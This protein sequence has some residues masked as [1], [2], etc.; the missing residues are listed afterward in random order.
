MK[1]AI[2]STKPFEK[3]FLEAANSQG[4]ELTFFAE[5]LS[6]ST[7]EKTKGFKAVSI[8]TNDDGS[9]KV[10]SRLAENKVEYIASRCA[11]IDNI[12]LA[13][14][15]SHGIKVANVPGYSPY[16]IAEHAVAMIM[17]MNR[18]IVRAD[19][20]VKDYDFRLDDLIGFD[21][22][23]KTAGIIGAGKIGGIVVKI[24]HGFGCRVL[25]FDP[26]E[27]EEL[28]NKYGLKYVSLDELCSQADIISI[29]APL[30]QHTRYMINE[31]RLSLMKDGVMIV[32][33]GRGPV[34]DTKAAVEGLKSGKI[35]YLGLDVYEYEKGLF[36]FDHTKDIPQDD[37]FA[38]LL[39]FKNVLITGHQAFLTSNALTN[40]A[41]TTFYNLNCWSNNNT[42][43]NEVSNKL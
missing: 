41:D 16:S 43:E 31:S 38:R 6:P 9:A 12:D 37:L 19:R 25:A 24:L 22:N 28:V 7:V 27:N 39:S 20:K 30:N 13:A 17:A 4:H 21:L 29:H 8:F 5:P 23:G 40:I 26:V 14:A 34:L 1:I 35:G 18:K 15:A 10:L 11:G 32:N 2:F 33:T 3:P 36:F 42:S